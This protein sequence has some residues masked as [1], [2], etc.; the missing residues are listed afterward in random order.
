MIYTHDIKDINNAF[1]KSS[2]GNFFN[3]GG[4]PIV[5][6]DWVTRVSIDLSGGADSALLAYL[7]MTELK[8]RN[9]HC[10]VHIINHVRCWKTKPW[11]LDVS[12]RVIDW[13]TNYYTN[14][15][16]STV[17]LHRNFIPEK[18]EEY[19]LAGEERTAEYVEIDEYRKYLVETLYI[20][21]HYNATTSHYPYASRAGEYKNR[22]REEIDPFQFVHYKNIESQP[23]IYMSKDWVV[24]Q[25]IDHDIMDLFNLT[26][27]C[28]GSI[29]VFEDQVD[30]KII[31]EF[32][33]E[34]GDDISVTCGVCYWCEERNW[35][36]EQ[37][38]IK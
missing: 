8:K 22:N 34:R 11:Q 2:A 12:D 20:D 14:N 26:R 6:D 29:E 7:L 5:L 9:Q 30:D 37:N 25:Y 16:H 15:F 13:L 3:V 18:Y 19:S 1:L 35:A 32:S 4:L 36:M 28:E 17:I 31:K 10:E 21:M 24:K 38:N 27:S 33:Y 23:F